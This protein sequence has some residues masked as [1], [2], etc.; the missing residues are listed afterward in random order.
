MPDEPVRRIDDRDACGRRS[1]AAH[2]PTIP[3][4]QQRLK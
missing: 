4:K 3:L 2:M 1:R